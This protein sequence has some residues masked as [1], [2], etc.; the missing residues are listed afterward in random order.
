MKRSNPSVERD[1]QPAALVG[2][3]RSFAV[4]AA[5]HRICPMNKRPITSATLLFLVS[6][7]AGSRNEISAQ[8]EA[9]FNARPTAPV[10]LALVGPAAWERVCVLGP[11][12]NN[13]RTQKTLGFKWDSEAHT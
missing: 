13:E 12:T 11:Y 2:S 1:R 6:A 3:L 4:P 7:C 10:N 9:Q 5:P 8:I